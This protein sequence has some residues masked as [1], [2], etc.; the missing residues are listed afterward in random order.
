MTGGGYSIKSLSS[1]VSSGRKSK[2]DDPTL[3]ALYKNRDLRV[4]TICKHLGISS[5]TM[6]D[7]LHKNGVA[8]RQERAA[9]GK[10]M[11]QSAKDKLHA[12]HKAGHSPRFISKAL[13]VSVATVKYHITKGAPKLVQPTKPAEPPA[14]PPVMQAAIVVQYPSIWARIKALFN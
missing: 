8:T 4:T 3:I 7:H 2:V 12:M 13:G 14:Q 5:M 9:K 11:T 1:N 10:R 6:Y